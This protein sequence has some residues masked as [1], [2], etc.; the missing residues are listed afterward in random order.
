MT[1]IIPVEA[2]DED[3]L[4]PGMSVVAWIPTGREGDYLLIPRD[5]LLQNTAGF[6]VYVVREGEEGSTAMPR[7]I[8]VVFETNGSVAVHPGSV[9]SNDAVIVEGN[10]RLYPTAP[11]R[12]VDPQAEEGQK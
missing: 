10:E 1:L 5:S 4:A 12:I 11:V 7:Q 9:Q 6:Y 2:K 3:L 8:D